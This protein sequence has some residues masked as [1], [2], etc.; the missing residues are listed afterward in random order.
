MPP[1]SAP[2]VPN[3]G[4]C[5]LQK[6]TFSYSSLGAAELGL[7]RHSLTQLLQE[8]WQGFIPSDTFCPLLLHGAIAQSESLVLKRDHYLQIFLQIVQVSEK[9]ML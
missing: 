8:S 7:S 2:Y 9:N 3:I 4:Q 6:Q 5:Q 1:H